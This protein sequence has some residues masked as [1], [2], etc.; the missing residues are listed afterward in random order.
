M[1]PLS[2]IAAIVVKDIRVDMRRRVEAGSMV[3][4]SVAS[5]VLASYVMG[6]VAGVSPSSLAL[7]VSLVLLF[8]TVYTSL[9]GFVREAEKGTFDGLR[10]APVGPETLFIAKVIYGFSL[11]LAS[12]LIFALV[13]AVF[14]GSAIVL[15]LRSLLSLT[16]SSLYLASVSSFTSAILVFSEARGTL[17][18]VMVLVLSL[19]YIQISVPV[20]VSVYSMAHVS[21]GKIASLGLSALGFST[22][23]TWLSRFVLEAE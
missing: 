4:F 12:S 15:S 19:P 5:A 1:E 8:L 10:A 2:K 9:A 13:L 18:P 6:G 21:F 22:L 14:S 20:L 23:A 11:L 7:A 17:M 3:V 16:F